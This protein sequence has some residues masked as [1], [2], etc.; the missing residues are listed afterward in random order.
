MLLPLHALSGLPAEAGKSR[1][2]DPTGE[3][4]RAQPVTLFGIPFVWPL[5][6]AAAFM[7]IGLLSRRLW[8]HFTGYRRLLFLP[9]VADATATFTAVAAWPPSW[10]LERRDWCPEFTRRRPRQRLGA[11]C[12]APT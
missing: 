7:P 11:P 3:V 6:L 8:Y 5:N 4:D 9:V 10:A 2:V 12:A 1:V